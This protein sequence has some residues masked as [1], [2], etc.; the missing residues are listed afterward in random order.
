[1]SNQGQASLMVQGGANSGMLIPLSGPPVTLG[2]RPD[3]DVVLDDTT[4]SRRHALIIEVPSGF[5][6][7][8]LSTTNGTYVNRSRIGDGEHALADG[9]RIRLADSEVVLVFRQDGPSTVKVDKVSPSADEAWSRKFTDDEVSLGEDAVPPIFGKDSDLFRLL[10]SKQGE[11]V[12]REDIARRLW[13]EL[14]EGGLADQVIAEAIVRIRAHVEEDP[15]HPEHLISVGE[16]GFLL[17]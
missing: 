14:M 16:S 10:R 1:M 12:S 6:L 9:D 13:P 3:N 2:R 4:V 15:E 7:R 8:D 17:V 5:V 11:V